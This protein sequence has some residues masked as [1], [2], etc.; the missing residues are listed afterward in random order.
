M[1]LSVY[2]KA[3]ESGVKAEDARRIIPQAAYTRAWCAMNIE[4][5]NNFIRLRTD[6]HA[7]AE[8]RLLANAILDMVNN[9]NTMIG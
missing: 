4:Q 5:Y 2:F 8:I 7:Q 1:C 9:N 3:I 6:S